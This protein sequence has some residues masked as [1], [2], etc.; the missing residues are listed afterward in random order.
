MADTTTTTYGL[1]KPEVG[2][3]EDT[4]GTKLN[5]NLD[6][7][8]DLLDGTSSIDGIDINSGTI[9]GTVIGDSVPAAGSFS[10]L[11]VDG[12]TLHVD[13]TNNR[14]G[15]GLSSPQSD[16]HIESFAPT[17]QILETASGETNRLIVGADTDGIYYNATFGV[18]G[19]PAHRFQ[20]S[21]IERAR[22]TNSGNVLIG[23]T[24]SIPSTGG[25]A[26]IDDPLSYILVSHDTGVVSG[27]YY[28]G[29]RYSTNT[30]GSITQNGTT[31]VAY[32]TSSDERLKQN[33]ADAPSAISDVSNIKVRSF[34]W[35]ADGSHQKYG[36]IAQELLTVA[37]HAVHQPV[38]PD[39]M[40]GVDYSKLVPML[41][42]AVQELSARVDELEKA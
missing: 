13:A 15:I 1:V 27:N 41:I 4:W 28:M 40:M 32:N 30:I 35:K 8:D 6:T 12:N 9:D 7:I 24:T 21:N 29:F 38:D 18:G 22:I 31:A 5:N 2:A 19:T 14:I 16:L 26:L 25:I 3:S 20:N 42:K 33:I 10:T 34:D 23:T 39:D 11:N 36:M 37:P 17:F